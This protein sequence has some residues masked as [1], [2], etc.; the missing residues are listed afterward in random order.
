M[1]FRCSECGAFT[2]R[3]EEL[4]SFDLTVTVAPQTLARYQRLL[5]TNTPPEGPELAYIRAIVSKTGARL[6]RLDDEISVLQD[7]LK[8]LEEERSALGDYHVQNTAMLS[9]LRR[10]PAEVL[11]EIFS[12]TLSPVHAPLTVK[13]LRDSPWVL[14][15]VSSRWRAIALSTS[16]LWSLVYIEYPG[17]Y[18]LA[19]IRAQVDRARTLK[20]H[21]SGSQRRDSRPQTE[22]FK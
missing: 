19:M 21:F 5:T 18:S 2:T 13:R 3:G 20:V 10:M 8:Q 7:R 17:I 1:S 14:T 12:W 16:S 9:P 4:G 6:T 11:S 22:M 15:H